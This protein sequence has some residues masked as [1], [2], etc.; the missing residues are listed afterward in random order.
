MARR[1]FGGFGGNLIWWMP[2]NEKFSGNLIWRIP[3]YR[4]FSGN[5]IWRVAEI[6]KKEKQQQPQFKEINVK[7]LM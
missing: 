4:N 7:I 5:L 6:V 3:K 2:K 1:K